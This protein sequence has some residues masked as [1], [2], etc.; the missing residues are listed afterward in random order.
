MGRLE[1]AVL[2][3]LVNAVWQTPVVAAAG[4]GAAFLLRRASA[5]YRY[6]LWV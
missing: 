4:F 6:R 2:T 1:G 3:F 5:A